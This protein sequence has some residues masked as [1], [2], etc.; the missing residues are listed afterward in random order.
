MNFR[1]ILTGAALLAASHALFAQEPVVLLNNADINC[2]DHTLENGNIYTFTHKKADGVIMLVIH[3][4]IKVQLVHNPDKKLELEH[5]YDGDSGAPFQFHEIAEDGHYALT[6]E[7]G[8][9]GA[10]CLSAAG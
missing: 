9:Q 7:K 6:I 1:N 10:V 5:G 8:G 4:D 3:G 2:R